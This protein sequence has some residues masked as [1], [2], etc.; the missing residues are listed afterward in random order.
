MKRLAI[1]LLLFL[2]GWS[3]P[4][5][6]KDPDPKKPSRQ[7]QVLFSYVEGVD[8]ELRDHAIKRLLTLGAKAVPFIK[9][10][11][12]TRAKHHYRY[13]LRRIEQSNRLRIKHEAEAD[14]HRAQ[15]N[16]Q[17]MLR[18]NWTKFLAEYLGQKL[19]R[20]KQLG[21][22]GHYTAAIALVEALLK[23]EPEMS[24]PLKARLTALRS[25][26]KAKRFAATAIQGEVEVP[27]SGELD[28]LPP[29]VI[30]GAKAVVRVHGEGALDD[31]SQILRAVL[32]RLPKHS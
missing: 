23:V 8:E 12:N 32:A 24:A 3:G 17:Q 20:V 21:S 29:H 6:A 11:L 26:Y 15:L 27:A 9:E 19:D 10:R 16:Q 13:I 7:L 31:R 28:Q 14:K 1:I 18:R 5:R 22:Q 2:V 25:T 30:G 4:L